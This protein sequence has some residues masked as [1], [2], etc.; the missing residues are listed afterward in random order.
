MRLRII[1]LVVATSS[2]VLVSFLVPL[3]L[4]LRSFAADRA[5]STATIQAQF[6]APLAATLDS[7]N[8][9]LAV[10]QVNAENKGAPLTVFLPGG[11]EVGSP[12]PR[13]AGVRLASQGRSFTTPTPA[14]VEVLVAVQG[15]PAGTAVIRTF[16][17]NATLRHGV[18]R[19]WLLLGG[20]GLGLLVLSVAVADQLARSLVRPLTAVAQVSDRLATGDLTARA[21][22]AG[23]PEVRRAGAGLNRLAARIGDLLAHER[24]TVADLSHRLRTPL[25]A[26]RI[27]A[28]SLRDEAEMAQVLAD[29]NIVERTVTEIIREARRP[30]GEGSGVLCDAS[31][32]VGERAAFWQPLAEDQDRPMMVDIAAGPV[33][34]RASAE[35]LAAC[36]DI[37]LENVFSHTLDGLAFGIRLSRRPGGGA[38]LLVA[39]DG[40]GFPVGNPTQRGLSNGGSSGLGLDIARRIA[41]NSGG[42]LTVGPST[43]GGAAITVE[44]GPPVRPPGRVRR[45][46]SASGRQR[47]QAQDPGLGLGDEAG[48]PWTLLESPPAGQRPRR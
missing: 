11:Q 4:V 40:P 25:T 13:S 16:V 26:L 27:D 43:S 29:V 31:D 34:V 18:D 6:M 41:E 32:V 44:L 46:R 17:P 35:D 36:T 3:A 7:N 33:M 38:W 24:E 8:L 9:K 19:A 20:V 21:T 37:L 47:P 12:A 42:T 1:L 45:H 39:D 28:E 2:L 48:P 5:V 23:P 14:G 22:V 10:D 30:T 15:L